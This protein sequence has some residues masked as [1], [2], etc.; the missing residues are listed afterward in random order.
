MKLFLHLPDSEAR[1]DESISLRYFPYGRGEKV[2]VV[3]GVTF[4]NFTFV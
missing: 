1:L 4:S 3:G 2:F